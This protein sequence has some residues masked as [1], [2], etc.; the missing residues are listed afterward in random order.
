MLNSVTPNSTCSTGSGGKGS[1]KRARFS[2]MVG[3]EKHSHCLKSK[4]IPVITLTSISI[5]P[6]ESPSGTEEEQSLGI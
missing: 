4:P 2:K 3:L 1:M 5:Q 6:F